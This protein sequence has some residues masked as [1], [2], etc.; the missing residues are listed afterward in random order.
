MIPGFNTNID[1]NGEGYHVQ[2]EDLGRGN[3][4]IL[5]LVYRAG[6]IIT[7][8][9]TNYR[10]LLGEKPGE[11]DIRSL[12]ER[13]HARMI[14]QVRTGGFELALPPPPPP[15]P[16]PSEAD[17]ALDDLVLRYLHAREAADL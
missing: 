11:A 5:T 8:I 10:D 9:K 17:R 4:F 7:R 13:Q 16:A 12:M 6:A 3:P 1:V 15:T 14:R 2:T